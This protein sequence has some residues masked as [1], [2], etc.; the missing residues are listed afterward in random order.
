MAGDTIF[1]LSSGA[2]PSGVAVI[3]LSGP[4]VRFA[5]ETMCS[6]V[7]APRAAMLRSIRS[8]NEEVLD[9]GLVIFFPGPG[10]FTGEDCAELQVHGGQATVTAI[11]AAL[12]DLDGLRM[13]EPG[14]F[15]RRGFENGK[16][17]LTEVEGLAD[18][19][20]AQTEVQRRFALELSSGGL[21]RLYAKWAD[22]LTHAR[23]MIEA[24]LDFSDEDDVPGS[25]SGTIWADMA[26]LRDEIADHLD[27]ARIGERVR[28][29]FKIV[30]AGA[31]NSGKSS[32]LNCL[33]NRDVAIVSEEAGTTRDII[34]VDMDIGGYAA[35]IS[36][37]A[38]LRDT[39][40]RVERE[41]IRRAE[42]AI[43]DADL[44]VLLQEPGG[45]RTIPAWS[46][47]TITV[48]T[49]SDIELPPTEGQHDVMISSQSGDGIAHLIELIAQR[50]GQAV[51]TGALAVPNRLRHRAHLSD[52]AQQI[53]LS[54]HD[55]YD[56]D[57]RAEHLRL[58]GEAL[59]RITGRVGAEDLLDVI[60]RQFC[61]GK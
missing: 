55:E 48:A 23:A 8:R 40:G 4:H 32:L 59:G 38:G 29:G 42:L 50:I 31:P 5:L 30:I 19:I 33:A 37:T 47:D 15:T 60:F 24:E 20:A 10:S 2:V 39:E 58:A 56:I 54:L 7:P 61:I 51:P 52:C 22:R 17:D 25:I 1:A 44:V 6:G 49:K 46:T 3:R 28:D 34:S 35:T 41:G 9:R 14:E 57:L 53:S 16:L 11:L 27:K 45:A 36:D 26:A 13:A 43:N 18:L 12:R 21:T